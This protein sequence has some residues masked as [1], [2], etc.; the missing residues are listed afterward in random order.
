MNCDV[1]TL[2]QN[3]TQSCAYFIRPK[4]CF[5]HYGPFMRGIHPSPVDSHPKGPVMRGLDVSCAASLNCWTNRLFNSNLVHNVWRHPDVCFTCSVIHGDVGPEEHLRVIYRLACIITRIPQSC[6]R[7]PQLT[8]CCV[9]WREV[10]DVTVIRSPE[11]ATVN[12]PNY[13]PPVFIYAG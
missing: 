4:T 5:P 3:T 12:G 6:C 7:D 13:I 2:K 1:I 11:T 8:I 9:F 10:Y